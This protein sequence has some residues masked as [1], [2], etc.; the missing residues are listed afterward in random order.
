MEQLSQT[1]SVFLTLA[2]KYITQRTQEIKLSNLSIP[3]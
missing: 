1:Q 2:K 3:S